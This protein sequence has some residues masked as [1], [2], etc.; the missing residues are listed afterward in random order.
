[1]ALLLTFFA[2]QNPSSNVV[3]IKNV[4]L[5]SKA[6]PFFG[7]YYGLKERRDEKNIGPF[8]FTYAPET[9]TLD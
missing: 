6:K 5:L 8:T 7:Y 3:L 2:E 4:Q 9:I 1:M